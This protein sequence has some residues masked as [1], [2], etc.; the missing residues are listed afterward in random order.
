M[1][2]LISLFLIL[3][4]WLVSQEAQ[5]VDFPPKTLNISSISETINIDGVLDESIWSALEK[6]GDFYQ[7]SPLDGILAEKKTEIQI[8]YDQSNIYVAATL[9][10]DEN[11]VI[12]SLKRD[13]FGEEDNFAIMLDPQNQNAN[14]YAFGVN[15][16]GAVTEALIDPND[17]DDGWDNKWNVAVK[18]YADRWTVEMAIPFKTLR[19]KKDNKVWGVNFYRSEPGANEEHVWSP[20]PRQFSSLDLGYFGDMVWDT[21][22]AP[23]GKNIALIPYATAS[24]NNDPSADPSSTSDINV[25]LDAKVG[26][27][28]GLNLDLTVNPDFSQVD[29]DRQVTNLTRFNIFFPERRHS[30]ST[31]RLQEAKP[32]PMIMVETSE[33]NSI[34]ALMI[35]SGQAR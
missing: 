26:L 10:D 11:Y 8:T 7:K 28:T 35:E 22:P 21:A 13:Q 17:A 15:A 31:D 18:N 27:S 12:N 5:S 29:V 19:F 16:R 1:K 3:P 24:V 30:S 34:S 9:Y 33:E 25:G 6:H 32:T 14:G 2:I 23:Q 4:F 20:V